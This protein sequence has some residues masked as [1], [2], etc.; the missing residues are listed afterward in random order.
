[1]NQVDLLYALQQLDLESA[2]H[3]KRLQ[4]IEAT[5][6]RNEALEEAKVALQQAQGRL[7]AA[8]AGLKDRELESQQT[9]SELRQTEQRLYGGRVRNPKELASL[10][11]KAQFL[12]RRRASLDD[13]LLEAM[14]ELD[15]ASEQNQ[16]AEATVQRLE[17]EWETT[18][19]TLAEERQRLKARLGELHSQREGVVAQVHPGNLQLYEVLRQHKGGR[20]IAPV[21]AKACQEC[22][23]TVPKALVNRAREGQELIRCPNCDRILV[24]A[25]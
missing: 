8:R 25:N 2:S 9:S 23:V 16:A 10:E 4:E 11:E 1:M 14:L 24:V 21:Q 13:D 17:A 3:G 20:A 12:K 15:E 19:Q 7:A 18:Q 22:G 5:L 6:A